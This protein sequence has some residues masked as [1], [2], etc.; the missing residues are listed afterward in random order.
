MSDTLADS[1]ANAGAERASGWLDARLGKQPQGRLGL[2]AAVRRLRLQQRPLPSGCTMTP[3]V[4][5]RGS[6]YA[7]QDRCLSLARQTKNLQAGGRAT[8]TLRAVG[9]FDASKAG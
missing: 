7:C 3:S 1:D 8:R 9:L 2:L 5:G 4:I 6:P